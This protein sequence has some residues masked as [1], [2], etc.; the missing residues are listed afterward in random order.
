[1]A[2]HAQ[3]LLFGM[4]H[5]FVQQ[6][7]VKQ[8]QLIDLGLQVVH[9]YPQVKTIYGYNSHQTILMFVSI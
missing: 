3:Q 7:P 4:V 6:L 8:A 1:M 5:P 9:G 2:Q